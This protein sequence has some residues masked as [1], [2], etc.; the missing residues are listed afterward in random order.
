MVTLDGFAVVAELSFK[1][2][3]PARTDLFPQ[4]G[5]YIQTPVPHYS[6]P[7]WLSIV[8]HSCQHL[9][10]WNKDTLR[11]RGGDIRP[12]DS[13]DD[14]IRQAEYDGYCTYTV[15]HD[16]ILADIVSAWAGKCPVVV[17]GE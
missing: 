10:I 6:V 7:F 16:I 8:N 15:N 2:C 9:R 17:E 1:L 13:C 5:Y 11:G 14:F 3:Q 4:A 12:S